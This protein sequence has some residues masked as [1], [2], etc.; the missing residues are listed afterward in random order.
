MGRLKDV[1]AR[2]WE[3]AGLHWPDAVGMAMLWAAVTFLFGVVWWLAFLIVAGLV[4]VFF[5]YIAWLE[6]QNEKFDQQ[7]PPA[8]EP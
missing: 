8:E 1:A 2:A 6:L 3:V 4:V 7:T 5:G